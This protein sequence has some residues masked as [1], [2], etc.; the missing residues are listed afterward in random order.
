[1]PWVP[2]KTLSILSE[3]SLL[4]LGL[5]AG[6]VG[7]SS[8]Y[9]AALCCLD[10]RQY[11]EAESLLIGHGQAQVRHRLQEQHTT[12]SAAMH[13]VSSSATGAPLACVLTTTGAGC[14]TLVYTRALVLTASNHLLLDAGAQRCCWLVPAGSH[15][16][17]HRP[18]S[19][20]CRVLLQSPAAGPY[21]VGGLL[22]A[23]HAR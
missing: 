11:T 16:P 19:Q 17:T 9:L 7:E 13:P 23:V 4:L 22:R 2:V 8:R 10:L 6:S 20:G 14:R 21:A 15:Q 12:P 18:P 3:S 5:P 1:M